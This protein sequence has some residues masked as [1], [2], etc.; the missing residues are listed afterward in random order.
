[1]FFCLNSLKL[2]LLSKGK[3][4]M[5]QLFVERVV[6]CLPCN[7][8]SLSP[9][10]TERAST[11]HSGQSSQSR[12]PH[13]LRADLLATPSASW[14]PLKRAPMPPLPACPGHGIVPGLSLTFVPLPGTHY[15]HPHLKKHSMFLPPTPSPLGHGHGHGAGCDCELCA[16]EFPLRTHLL[17][18]MSYSRLNQNQD[19]QTTSPKTSTVSRFNFFSRKK[20]SSS[21]SAAQTAATLALLREQRSLNA[22]KA[23]KAAEEEDMAASKSLAPVTLSTLKHDSLMIPAARMAQFFPA[24]HPI[25]TTTSHGRL[26]LLEAPQQ[27]LKVV[28]HMMGHAV[29]VAPAL[30]S[31]L[32]DLYSQHR[33]CVLK[34]F[35]AAVGGA[36]ASSAALQGMV[37]LNL[38]RGGEMGAGQCHHQEYYILIVYGVPFHDIVGVDGRQ[39]DYRLIINKLR[40]LSLEVFDPVKTGFSC[41]HL[42]DTFEEVAMLARPPLE[43][44]ARKATTSATGYILTVFKV[45][46]GDDSVKFERNWLSWTGAGTLYKS[47]SNEVG[48]RRLTLHKSRS[49]GGMLHYILLCDCSNFL[50]SIH[51]AVKAIPSL[52]MRLCGDMGL[53][54]PISTY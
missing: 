51:Q 28:F 24:G 18:D 14:P 38:E 23:L 11:C 29:H 22:A 48:L 52:R 49:Q 40:N 19:Q 47:L 37:L 31:P 30:S 32:Q 50:T 5:F 4:R 12:Q 41:P 39:C 46:E 10:I 54:R 3:G 42:F 13:M 15:P 8:S 36:G 44:I 45:F 26:R 9:C 2:N 6:S 21:S 16:T 7:P 1:M 25:P 33:D 20:T 17:I 35:R 34:A 53:Y 43:K 27:N